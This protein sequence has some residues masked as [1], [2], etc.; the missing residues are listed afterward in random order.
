VPTTT[1]DQG[2]D[3]STD[4]VLVE[5]NGNANAVNVTDLTNGTQVSGLTPTTNIINANIISDSL[6]ISTFGGSDS[7]TVNQNGATGAVRR[8]FVNAGTEQDTI[9][10]VGTPS[11]GFVGILPSTG[12]DS[13]SVNSDNVLTANVT[14]EGTQRIGQLNVNNGGRATLTPGGAKVLTVTSLSVGIAGTLNL[15]DNDMIVDY[16]GASPIAPVQSLL[17]AGRGTGSWN[18]SSGITTSLGN[19]STFALGYAEAS[20]VAPGGTFSGQP[21]DTTAI[22]VKYT[23]YGD[24]N[25][26]GRV[27]VTDLGRL[28]SNWQQSSRRWAQGDFSYDNV[29]NVTDLGA[30]ATNWQ[31]GAIIPLSRAMTSVRLSTPPIKT[32]IF[33]EE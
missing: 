21:V 31:A 22:V 17:A 14:F 26:D 13:V 18:T 29:V 3:A 6:Q 30:L 24:A 1:I 8:V 25:L 23:F 16:T 19:A 33:S 2:N 28:A 11:D 12:D 4:S 7:I 15:T 32:S 5:A 20:D 9:N 27:N 10:V